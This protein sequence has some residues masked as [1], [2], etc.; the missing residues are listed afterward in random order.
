[1]TDTISLQSWVQQLPTNTLVIYD[2]HTVRP[3]RE[4]VGLMHSATPWQ[5][6]TI[7]NGGH[8]APVTHPDVINPIIA[9]FLNW[10]A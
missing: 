1:M 2:V 8:M 9:E 3:I 6:N 4:I 10:S 5:F 7:P